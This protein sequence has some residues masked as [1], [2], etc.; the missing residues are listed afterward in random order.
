MI[1]YQSIKK[2]LIAQRFF[3]I[4][5]STAAKLFTVNLSIVHLI[6]FNN[7]LNGIIQIPFFVVPVTTLHAFS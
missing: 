4:I 1:E 7:H 3:A 2:P 6:D 5:L